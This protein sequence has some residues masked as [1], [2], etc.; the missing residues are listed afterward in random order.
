MIYF[1]ALGLTFSSVAV[2]VI[3]RR[4][5]AVTETEKGSHYGKTL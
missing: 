2:Y 1:S 5:I 3:T 4:M